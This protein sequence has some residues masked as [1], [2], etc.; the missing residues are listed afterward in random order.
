MFKNG[1]AV[2]TVA[3]GFYEADKDACSWIIK[4]ELSHI[5]HNDHFTMLC[6]PCVCQLAAAIF[7]M[8]FL[9]FFPALGLAYAVGLVSLV[10]FARWREAKADDFAIENSSNEELKG[11]RRFFMAVQ[12][13]NIEVRNTFWRRFTISASGDMRLDTF[14]PSITSRIQKIER[15]LSARNIDKVYT[16]STSMAPTKTE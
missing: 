7:G 11:G 16:P 1:D 4:H 12:Q 6:V 15:A 3:P 9:S 2:V 13:T 10:L 8:C 14:H 5:K